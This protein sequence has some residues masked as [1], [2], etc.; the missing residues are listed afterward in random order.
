VPIFNERVSWF[1]AEMVALYAHWVGNVIGKVISLDPKTE[2]TK[3]NLASTSRPYLN[4]SWVPTRLLA[5][6]SSSQNNFRNFFNLTG[7]HSVSFHLCSIL[8]HAAQFGSP[9]KQVYFNFKNVLYQWSMICCS[10]TLISLL[11]RT[12]KMAIK[13]N[14]HLG[15]SILHSTWSM[16]FGIM[17]NL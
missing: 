16:E 1:R 17:I 12:A 11:F 7:W 10:S 14:F 2:T 15:L 4:P 5:C 3:H 6:L 8:A 9:L 13:W